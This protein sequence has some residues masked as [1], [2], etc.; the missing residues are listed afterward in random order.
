MIQTDTCYERPVVYKMIT[1]GR[2]KYIQLDTWLYSR[3]RF[4]EH[5]DVCLSHTHLKPVSFVSNNAGSYWES[6]DV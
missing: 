5:Q 1:S 2:D 4:N 3:A 6:G